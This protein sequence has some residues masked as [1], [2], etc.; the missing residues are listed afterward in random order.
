M[1]EH[2]LDGIWGWSRPKGHLFSRLFSQ[3][4]GFYGAIYSN[5]TH[6]PVFDKRSSQTQRFN[7]CFIS[8]SDRPSAPT[9]T[10][11]ARFSSRICKMGILSWWILITLLKNSWSCADLPL[12]TSNTVTPYSMEARLWRA[13]WSLSRKTDCYSDLQAALQVCSGVWKGQK[14]CR[15][16]SQSV[17]G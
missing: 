8:A 17:F 3:H 15:T 6:Y 5:H 1:F 12:P 11:L 2:G 9:T 10:I 7:D 13:H 14:K 4:L 16:S